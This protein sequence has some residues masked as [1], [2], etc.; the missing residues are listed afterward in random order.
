[1]TITGMRS[2]GTQ[3]NRA[4]IGAWLKWLLRA[5]FLLT[6][7]MLVNSVYLIAVTIGEALSGRILQ[8]PFYLLMFLGHL[9]LG[10]LL[11][12]PLLAFGWLHYR[13]AR[14]H[15]NRYAKRA[16][17]AL[18]VS[19]VLLI[20]TG[21]LLTR[22][23][24]FEINAPRVRLP[25]YW[26]HVLIPVVAI[27]LF[28]LHRLAGPRIRWRRGI[29]WGVASLALTGLLVAPQWLSLGA[30]EAEAALSFAPSQ[31]RLE[32]EEPLPARLLMQ[33]DYC[34]QC[35]EDI[36]AQT[37]GS[38]HKLSS[39]NNP[40]YRASIDDT[41]KLLRQRDGNT[42]QARL[43]AAC[44]D[45]APLFSGQFDRADFDPDRDASASAGITC[46][47]CHAISG[48]TSIKG[49]GSYYFS[50]PRFYPFTFSDNP[51]LQSINRQLIRAKPEFHKETLLRPLHRQA[52]FCA[53]CHKVH[54]PKSLNHYRWLRGQ[55][56]YDSFL[57][58]GVSGH[59]VD[60]FYYP[61]KARE[62]CAACH[63]PLTPSDDPAAR[64]RAEKSRPVVHH[65]GFHAANTGVPAMLKIEPSHLESRQRFLR[66]AARIDL[67]ALRDGPSLES[68]LRA[69]LEQQPPTLEPG[70]SYLLEVVVRTT[71]VGHQL[72]QGTVDSN[73]LWL[74]I[75]A[76]AGERKLA[77]SGDLGDDGA[78]DPEAYFL[79]AFLLDRN[80]ERISRRN[81][82][83]I[84]VALYDHQIP[85][86]AA[87]VVRYRLDIPADVDGPV[88]IDAKLNYRKFD[89]RYV[90]YVEGDRFT[91]NTLPITVMA[92]DAITLPVG[93]NAP[94]PPPKQVATENWERWNDYG[95]GLL[96]NVSGG[97]KKGDLRLAENAFRVVEKLKPAHGAL[98]L[99][100][101]Y[102]SEG[103]LDKA[104]KLLDEAEKAGGYPWTIAWY[105]A[106]I[107]QQR[108]QLD[109]AEK[110][111]LTLLNT[112]FP[113]VRE[114]G[115]DFSKDIRA[116]NLLGQVY[117]EQALR[118]RRS[119]RDDAFQRSLRQAERA[120]L[121]TLKIDP[122][123]AAAHFNLAQLYT[124]KG[125]RQKAARHREL[126]QR[127]RPD[128]Q[129][130]EQ[131]VA[132]RRQTDPVADH[133][134]DAGAIYRLKAERES[135]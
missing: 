30:R 119:P 97:A 22:F 13:R 90:R 25:A 60:S 67:F 85:P 7:L 116:V 48:L 75:T 115:F 73:E 20:V 64:R 63:M 121:Q 28:V 46:L 74:E 19:A 89:T 135:L 43:C 111:L 29:G 95:I 26:L 27:W 108:G 31:A 21:L 59:R 99:A 122:E 61:A 129:A 100:R 17:L 93:G 107:A 117:Y 51:L 38:M 114:R 12:G 126:H 68:P 39:F 104:D 6:G 76:R 94:A 133:A 45:Q 54:I 9:A 80:G 57:L 42:D 102:F 70:K 53:V 3:R 72:T 128:D 56:H 130:V 14:R 103:E 49:N 120:W 58:S 91:K 1:M 131:A 113:Q 18:Y 134:A 2:S 98:N 11:M 125:D 83:D 50:R 69:P 55:D 24:F 106:R 78:V 96:R 15:P 86:G 66:R 16:G 4:V 37:A 127:Y 34:A 41:R 44:H 92:E 35:H 52:E 71:G 112:D 84:F 40:A 5:V 77:V 101:L 32:G 62:N 8:D 82:Q 132:K 87:S 124:L 10:L 65:H 47:G 23:P 36:A 123:N 118:L 105:R 110:Q 88:T 81:A 33:D 79:N 109:Q